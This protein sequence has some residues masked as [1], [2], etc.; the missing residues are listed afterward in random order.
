MLAR[1]ERELGL[2]S[3]AITAQQNYLN[4]STDEVLLGANEN[5]LK[6]ELKRLPLLWRIWRSFDIVHFNSGQTLMPQ[7]VMRSAGRY[8]SPLLSLY[9]G[10]VR[11]VELR[12]LPVLKAMGKGIVVTFQGD[13][14]RQGDYCAA[15]FAINAVNEVEPGYYTGAADAHRRHRIAQIARYADRIYAL[16]PDLLHVL[17]RQ[18][19]FLPYASV[20][21][22][23]W[24]PSISANLPAAP[25]VLHAP[26]HRG[27]K[28]TRFV[29]EAVQRLE[30]EGTP[31][32]F[33]LVEGLSNAE[34]RQLYQQADL[35]VDQLLIGWYGGLAV[36][37][38]AL[39]KPVVCYIREEDLKFIPAA[40]R[41]ELPIINATPAT[42]YATLK[43]WLTDRKDEL[44]AVGRKS[45]A[46]AERWHDPLAIAGELKRDYAAI[47][48]RQ[49]KW[50]RS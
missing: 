2:A 27:V 10:Y 44:A 35:L 23:Q 25:T 29:L 3:W 20:D 32:K 19:Q 30:S 43:T 33:V 18:A 41:A 45:R 50:S 7:R 46:F 16:N 14:A 47:L 5:R 28:G 40:M 36:E 48:A 11:L 21:P 31:F 24:Q 1:S 17:P 15:H 9:Q 4:Y 22:R 8:S 39:G 42:I 12:D 34:A 49:P 6:L 13:D 37:L 38:M 26:S